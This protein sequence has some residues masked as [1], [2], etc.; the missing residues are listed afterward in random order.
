MR[1]QLSSIELLQS[2]I[3]FIRDTAMPELGAPARFNA[4]IAC[5]LLQIAQREI[6]QAPAAQAAEL[7]RLRLLLDRTDS[8]L[9]ELNAELCAR[10]SDGKS[11][12]PTEGLLDHLWATTLDKLAVDQ[13]DYSSYGRAREL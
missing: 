9:P 13:P 4:R 12:L 8:E 3:E 11:A 5:N 2:V 1:D 10:I 6:E 7:A